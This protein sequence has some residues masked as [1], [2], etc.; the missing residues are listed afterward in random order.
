MIHKY[1]VWDK[2]KN[3]MVYEFNGEPVLDGYR[4]Y[5]LVWYDGEL[6][7]SHMEGMLYDKRYYVLMQNTGLKDKNGKEYY[8]G[9]I[10]DF[11]IFDF[12]GLD[13]QLRGEIKWLPDAFVFG[14]EY[15]YAGETNVVDLYTL[16][17]DEEREIIGNIHQNPE[18]LENK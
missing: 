10:T 9:D 16:A 13:V 14:V 7:L 1:R 6:C 12:N 2:E 11:T 18:L 4:E 15:I 8:D 3:H 17:A 5:T